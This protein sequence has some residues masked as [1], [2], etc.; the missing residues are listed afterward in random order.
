MTANSSAGHRRKKHRRVIVP[1]APGVDPA[2]GRGTLDNTS[3]D[4]PPETH[5]EAT[6]GNDARLKGD[7]PPHWG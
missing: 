1:P 3:E 6:N 2:P 5:R 4:E 7:K